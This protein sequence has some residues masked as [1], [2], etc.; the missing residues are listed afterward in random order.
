VLVGIMLLSLT[1]FANVGM[2]VIGFGLLCMLL[3]SIV[4]VTSSPALWRAAVIQGGAPLLALV[5]YIIGAA[6]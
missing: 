4:L 1:P 5:L 3:A 6:L 2:A